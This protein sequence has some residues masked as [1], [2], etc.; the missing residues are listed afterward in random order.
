MA[1]KLLFNQVATKI[2]A[3]IYISIQIGLRVRYHIKTS[4]SGIPRLIRTIWY[5][6]RYISIKVI[7]DQKSAKVNE[8]F[9]FWP[10]TP[11]L[12]IGHI[13]NHLFLESIMIRRTR[14]N[15]FQLD[16]SKLIS[17][18]LYKSVIWIRN[19]SHCSKWKVTHT[20]TKFGPKIGPVHLPQMCDILGKFSEIFDF[21]CWK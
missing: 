9:T 11:F 13:A 12:N 2:K 14:W 15:V 18:S 19:G 5:I 17:R 21:C 10:I 4:I 7:F 20:F 3:N 16:W 8:L 6:T 1:K